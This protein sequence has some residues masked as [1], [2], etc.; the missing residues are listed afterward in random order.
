MEL[1]KIYHS[2]FYLL[3]R[4]SPGYSY[5]SKCGKPWNHCQSK[6]VWINEKHGTFATCVECWDNSILEELKAYYRGVYFWQEDQVKG[7]MDHSLETL[8]NAVE[9][10][11][12]NGKRNNS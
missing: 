11:Y 4:N 12:N 10:E 6:T 5:C 7:I 1:N 9:R 2:D 3:R 8:L